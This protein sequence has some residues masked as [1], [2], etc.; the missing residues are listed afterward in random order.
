MV[1][2]K[3][4]CSVEACDRPLWFDARTG[5]S[6][7][8]KGFCVAHYKRY[9]RH[10]DPEIVTKELHGLRKAP[11]YHIWAN[12]LQRCNNSSATSYTYY[13]GRGIKVCKRWEK[14][15]KD[16]LEDMGPRPASTSIDRINVNGD[17]EPGNCRWA[18][19]QIQALNRRPLR[20]NSSGKPGVSWDKRNG[21]WLAAIFADGKQII[22]GRFSSKDN[23]IKARIA[24][25]K[26]YH[27]PLINDV[28]LC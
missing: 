26:I 23:A 22:I 21:K 27:R 24:A 8:I 18:T 10:G 13:G 16:F 4:R 3:T 1:E 2:A 6:Y 9:A 28:D 25:E 15:F 11:E 19:A 20:A 7:V 17:Y 14:S 12:M 5:R